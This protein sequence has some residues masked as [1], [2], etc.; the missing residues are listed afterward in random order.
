MSL[1]CRTEIFTIWATRGYFVGFLGSSEHQIRASRKRVRFGHFSRKKRISFTY[2]Y[3]ARA[4]RC[5]IESSEHEKSG[6]SL[7]IQYLHNESQILR[8]TQCPQSTH[9]GVYK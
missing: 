2:L 5:A 4:A 1:G 8:R 9:D 7:E 3:T 6:P